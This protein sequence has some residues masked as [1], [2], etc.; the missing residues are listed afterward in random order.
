[1]RRNELSD[2]Q[3]ER[4]KVHLPARKKRGRPLRDARQMLNGM[5]WILR[6][7]APWRDLPERYGP[8]KTVYE[9]F[10]RWSKD[11]TIERVVA[12]LQEELDTNKRIDWDLFFVDGTSIRASRAAAGARKKSSRTNR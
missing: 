4:V 12:R 10:R 8:W 5:L 7:G 11:G 9:T 1:M 2:T 6:T 3:W